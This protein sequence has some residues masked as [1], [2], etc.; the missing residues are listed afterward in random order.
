MFN[1]L[2]KLQNEEDENW[3]LAVVPLKNLIIECNNNYTGD[4]NFDNI[5]WSADL[6]RDKEYGLKILCQWC[7][8][9]LKGPYN[10]LHTTVRIKNSNDFLIFKL[11]WI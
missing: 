3:F 10:I 1:T 2:K 5:I 8:D 6:I 11:R 7:K 9:N 4:S